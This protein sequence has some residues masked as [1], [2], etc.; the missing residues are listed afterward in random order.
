MFLEVLILRRKS[1]RSY[2]QEG[3]YSNIGCRRCS[4]NFEI[5]GT[6]ASFRTNNQLFRM[7][8]FLYF[9][10][11]YEILVLRVCYFQC[12]SNFF[13]YQMFMFKSINCIFELCTVS[14][15]WIISEILL[16]HVTLGCQLAS[17]SFVR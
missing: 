10:V 15:Y 2:A 5:L 13:W 16:L 7:V 1:F 11:A 12:L 8:N 14:Q 17:M 9:L 3:I 4:A 6:L